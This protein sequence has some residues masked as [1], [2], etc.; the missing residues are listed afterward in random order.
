MMMHGLAYFKFIIDILKVAGHRISSTLQAIKVSK[1]VII[2]SD[3]SSGFLFFLAEWVMA[4]Y[5]SS[6]L[7]ALFLFMNVFDFI[8]ILF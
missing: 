4:F 8:L 5:F 1:I 6:C 3:S 2:L 7:L